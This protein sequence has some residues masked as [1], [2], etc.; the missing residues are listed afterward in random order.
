MVIF[1]A[2]HINFSCDKNT[3]RIDRLYER[4]VVSVNVNIWCT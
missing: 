1:I 3:N 4:I 2:E